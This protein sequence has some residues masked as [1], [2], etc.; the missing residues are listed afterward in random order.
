MLAMV[1]DR[2]LVAPVFILGL[3]KSLASNVGVRNPWTSN[4]FLGPPSDSQ[5][6]GDSHPRRAAKIH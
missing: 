4:D 2:A 5:R 3:G 1:V 6:A